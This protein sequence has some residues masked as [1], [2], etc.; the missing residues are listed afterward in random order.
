MKRF[1]LAFKAVLKSGRKISGRLSLEAKG[2]EAA[3]EKAID[4]VVTQYGADKDAVSVESVT[5]G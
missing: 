1:T 4:A 3:R 2:Q 5:K